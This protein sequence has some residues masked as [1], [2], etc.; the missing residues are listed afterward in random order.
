MPAG[1]VRHRTQPVRHARLYIGCKT[2]SAFGPM[3]DHAKG[4]ILTTLGVLL[5][6]PD[7]LFVRLIDAEPMIVAFWRSLTAGAIVLA[8]VLATRAGEGFRAVLG[9]GWPGAIYIVMI[10]TTAPGFVLAISNTSVANA[11]FIF[12]TTPIFAALFSRIFLGEPIG[13]RLLLTIAAVIPGVGLIA[14]GSG[15][16]EVASWQGDLWALYVSAAYAAAL[17]ALRRVRN[18]SMIPAI[19]IA[20]IG[21]ALVIGLFT[22]PFQAFAGNWVLFL[23]HGLFIGAATCLLTLGP[24]YIRSGE[25]ALLILL[26]S[27]L[28]PLLVWAVI[29][30]HPGAWA[31]AGGTVV[32]GVLLISNLVALSGPS[33]GQV[34]R[35]GGRGDA[36]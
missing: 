23:G 13:G 1:D 15:I 29:G 34:P 5:V 12:A 19:P 6:V 28:A 7:S 33:G 18:I 14:L 17:T 4:L 10:G 3:T 2:R 20:Y 11:V 16:S 21:A 24:R 25:V 22:A 9:S 26:E 30:E 35:D 8:A 27:V 36:A 31:L 32:I